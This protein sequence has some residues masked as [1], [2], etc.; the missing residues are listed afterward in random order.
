MPRSSDPAADSRID[1]QVIR[2]SVGIAFAS[3]HRILRRARCEYR[4]G[5][6]SAQAYVGAVDAQPVGESVT[7]TET[8]FLGRIVDRNAIGVAD[9]GQPRVS[10]HVEAEVRGIGSR[11]QARDEQQADRTY[12][13]GR[14]HGRR[15]ESGRIPLEGPPRENH[16]LAAQALLL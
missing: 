10:F 1:T 13:V 12:C 2:I 5:F 6:E 11:Q 3:N 15:L 8:E 4:A 16:S 9:L 7:G 14:F